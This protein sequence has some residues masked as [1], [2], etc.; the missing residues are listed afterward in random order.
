MQGAILAQELLTYRT[1]PLAGLVTRAFIFAAAI[2]GEDEANTNYGLW[3]LRSSW[4]QAP[5]QS[6]SIRTA[7]ARRGLGAYPS[8]Y[9]PMPLAAAYATAAA[10]V[11]TPSVGAGRVIAT[12]AGAGLICVV[13]PPTDA[14]SDAGIAA[15][16]LM[17]HYPDDS[18]T[19][20]WPSLPS[21]TQLFSGLG[22]SLHINATAP[23]AS[24]Y[25]L[26]SYLVIPPGQ[27][28]GD[29]L[30]SGLKDN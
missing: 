21:G 12:T 3:R 27:W 13:F 9:V 6:L 10:M 2:P 7:G 16:W 8:D 26:P 14:A 17:S 30:C 15:L 11:D 29:P 19:V 5:K 20:S 4:P 22:A 18:V 28:S 23:S 25:P 1:A 24:I